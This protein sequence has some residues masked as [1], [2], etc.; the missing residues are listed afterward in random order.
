MENEKNN[1]NKT[2]SRMSRIAFPRAKYGALL[3]IV[4]IFLILIIL[5]KDSI[6]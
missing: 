5:Y 2:P 6:L 3:A 1:I 4:I